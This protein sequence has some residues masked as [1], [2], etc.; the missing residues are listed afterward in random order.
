[1]SRFFNKLAYFTDI[2][3]GR[4][5]GDDVS[6]RD[7]VEFVKWFVDEAKARGCETFIFGGDYFDNRH[8]IGVKTLN[9]GLDCMEIL[10][11]SFDRCYFIPGNHDLMFRSSRDV[12]SI[13]FGRNLENVEIIREPLARDDVVLLPWLVGEEMHSLKL[14]A[15]KYVF[16]HLEVPGFL[17]NAMVEMPDSKHAMKADTL[18]D[19]GTVFT[20]HFHMRQEKGNIVYTG[21]VMPFN[22]SDS[23]D[24]NRGAM[25]LEWGQQ[26]EF[27]SW[28]DQ[29]LY[30]AFKLSE[31]LD[32]PDRVLTK[33]L[34]ARVTLDADV[35]YEEAQVIKDE[36]VRAYGMRKLELVHQHKPEADQEFDSDVVFQSIDQIV[37]DGLKAMTGGGLDPEKLIDIYKRLHV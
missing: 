37:I 28:P 35:S 1:M 27:V 21:N 18:K 11:R 7:N 17:M 13:E 9:T 6:L 31:L 8:T 22:F 19:H 3:F 29:P 4:R 20:G 34:S 10:S 16:A 36:F 15:S 30:R 5:G 2:H 14:P 26:P 12:I 23:W 32:D 24:E 25:F 33:N